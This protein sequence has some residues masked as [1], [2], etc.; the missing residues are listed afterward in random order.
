[1]LN[2]L[3]DRIESGPDG[4]YVVARFGMWGVSAEVERHGRK[5]YVIHPNGKK[6][7]FK[8]KTDAELYMKELF[9]R[10]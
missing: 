10:R 5:W 3:T 8:T 9:E 2:R 1:M 6:E 4:E 7:K